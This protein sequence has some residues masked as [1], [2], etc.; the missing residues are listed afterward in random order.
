MSV[1]EFRRRAAKIDRRMQQSGRFFSEE[2]MPASL[3]ALACDQA[4]VSDI[5]RQDE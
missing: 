1:S 2:S 3:L 5:R 4:Q